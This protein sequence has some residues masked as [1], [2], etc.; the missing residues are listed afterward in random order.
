MTIRLHTRGLIIVVI[1]DN[2]RSMLLQ[3]TMRCELEQVAT[4][5]T[6]A[7]NEKKSEDKKN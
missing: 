5:S 1:G 4:W 2:V 6:A 7:K 3:N